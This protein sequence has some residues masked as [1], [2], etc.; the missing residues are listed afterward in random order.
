[1]MSGNLQYHYKE[2]RE[3]TRLQDIYKQ[4]VDE[5]HSELHDTTFLFNAYTETRMC[6]HASP[7]IKPYTKVYLD[8]GG[9]QVVT[10][11]RTVTPEIKQKVYDIQADYGDYGFCFDEI[12]VSTKEGGSDLLTMSGRWFDHHRVEE[13]A[14]ITAEN[15]NKQV[16]T[17]LKR[18]SSCKPIVIIQGN[19]YD[20]FMK[21]AEIL[22][23]YVSDEVKPHI[24]GLAMA[25]TS[26][27]R[28]QLEDLDKCFYFPALPLSFGKDHLHL[29]AVGSVS[30]L[31]PTLLAMQSGYYPENMRISYDST[32]ITKYYFTGTYLMPEAKMFAVKKQWGPHYLKLA[33]DINNNYPWTDFD[34]K[35]IHELYTS[36]FTKQTEKSAKDG[37]DYL[38]YLKT[39]LMS[40]TQN[41]ISEVDSCYN[42]KSRLRELFARSGNESLFKGLYSMKDVNDYHSWRTQMYSH[43][44]SKRIPTSLPSSLEEFF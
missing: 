5:S 31:A 2:F 21:W 19:C 14:R 38:I 18:E 42:S 28:G 15:I 32:T 3:N 4:L 43:L 9:L 44:G 23:K 6:E 8:S 30:R 24:G 34:A 27:G 11:G 36:T 26:L 12:P 25:G 37:E 39:H 41:F 22:E 33:E 17:Y 7:L 10:L 29:L 35:R 16:E 20:S 1:M 40:S 13:C